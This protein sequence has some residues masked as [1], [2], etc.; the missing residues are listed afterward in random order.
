MGSAQNLNFIKQIN[1]IYYYIMSELIF[2]YYNIILLTLTKKD[3]VQ[4]LLK[5]ESQKHCKFAL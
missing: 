1:A 2:S 4:D 3:I 5:Y